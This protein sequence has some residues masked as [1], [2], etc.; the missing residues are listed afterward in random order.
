MVHYLSIIRKSEFTDLFKY[1][2]LYINHCVTFD[3]ELSNHNQDYQFFDFLTHNITMFEYSFEYLVIHFH[4][5]QFKGPSFL[6]SIADVDS[7]YAFNEEAKE[8]MSISFD[9]KIQILVSPWTNWFTELQQ[10]LYLKQCLQGVDNIWHILDLDE[11]EK[12]DCSEIITKDIISEVIRQLFA[13]KRPEGEQSLWIYLMRYERHS[14]YPKNLAG[15]F[16]DFIH[17]YCNWLSKKE[18]SGEIA[19]ETEV[20]KHLTHPKLE[21][22]VSVIENTDLNTKTH[23]ATQCNFYIVAPLFLYYKSVFAEGF[24]LDLKTKEY[25]ESEF[26]NYCKE[27]YRSEFVI[28]AYLLGLTLG[29]DKTYNSYYNSIGLSIFRKQEITNRPYAEP[30]DNREHASEPIASFGN[31]LND[32]VTNIKGENK[33]E[34][35][36]PIRAELLF[37]DDGDNSEPEKPVAQNST[38]LMHKGKPGSSK[39]ETKEVQKEEVEKY[40]HDGWKRKRDKIK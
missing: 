9:P 13:H 33:K 15:Y 24:D 4:T 31:E 7:I 27:K 35:N 21:D 32:K 17:L 38:I 8:E 29:H 25:S 22:L 18:L 3:G 10:K 12:K 16:Y 37:P 5:D 20:A 26:I 2:K 14:M 1:G 28:C 40:T 19:E 11:K 30:D 36:E 39:Y 23:Q 6:I 34:D